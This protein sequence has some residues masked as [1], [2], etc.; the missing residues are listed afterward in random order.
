MHISA[1]KGVAVKAWIVAQNTHLH[2][3]NI[4]KPIIN[5]YIRIPNYNVGGGIGHGLGLLPLVQSRFL[6]KHRLGCK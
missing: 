2:H 5:E 1:K 4:F 3:M 6:V